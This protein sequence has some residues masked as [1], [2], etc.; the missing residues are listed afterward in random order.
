MEA[1]DQILTSLE[2]SASTQFASTTLTYFKL[3]TQ[4]NNNNNINNNNNGIAIDRNTEQWVMFQ[5][6]RSCQLEMDIAT[7]LNDMKEQIAQTIR[8]AEVY[9]ENKYCGEAYEMLIRAKKKYG[10]TIDD[11]INGSTC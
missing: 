3:S 7:E 11:F 5:T 4:N 9:S 6:M 1:L 2:K 8:L 10:T